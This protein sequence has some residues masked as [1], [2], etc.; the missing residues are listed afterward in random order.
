MLYL[1]Y[2]TPYYIPISYMDSLFGDPLIKHTKQDLVLFKIELSNLLVVG[3][4]ETVQTYF[5]QN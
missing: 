4:S 1:N 3:T 2:I 5:I